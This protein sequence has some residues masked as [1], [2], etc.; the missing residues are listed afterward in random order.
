VVTLHTLDRLKLLR[1]LPI[2]MPLLRSSAEFFG[3]GSIKIV[4]L[5]STISVFKE[6]L[7]SSAA[8]LTLVSI[9]FCAKDWPYIV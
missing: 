8:H 1:A 6:R 3:G 7:S 9:W 2:S 4:L 5:R